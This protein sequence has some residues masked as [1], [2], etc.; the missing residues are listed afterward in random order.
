MPKSL[1]KS[2]KWK[3][4]YFYSSDH[5]HWNNLCFF[6]S[7]HSHFMCQESLMDLLSK[8]YHLSSLPLILLCVY[9]Q[10]LL[11]ELL[12]L[13]LKWFPWFH[14]VLCRLLLKQL[15]SNLNIRQISLYWS[16][17]QNTQLREENLKVHTIP[18]GL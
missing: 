7:Y 6:L 5:Q 11:S 8:Y 2:L 9:H 17:V 1:S 3:H 15:Y 12:Q 18:K 16:S 4:H 13:P 14:L 10:H